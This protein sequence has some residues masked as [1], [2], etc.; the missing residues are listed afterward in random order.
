MRLH[1]THAGA[2]KA[3]QA[4]L[5]AVA[6]F[7]GP[8]GGCDNSCVRIAVNPGGGIISG[9]DST[10]TAPKMTGN[11]RVS[12]NASLAPDA[13]SEALSSRHIFVSLRGVEALA[14]ALAGEDS[15]GWQEMAPGLATRPVQVDLLA[16][17]TDA[18]GTNSLGEATIPQGVYN[19]V[20]LRFVPN[21]PGANELV[22]EENACGRAGFNCVVAGDDSARPIV[23]GETAELRV[24]AER[25][26][27]RFFRVLPGGDIHLAVE[28]D[29]RSS[30]AVP[31]GDGVRL[32]PAFSA[33]QQAPCET[34]QR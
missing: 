32:F 8:L 13:A 27:G 4:G 1:G 2:A 26:E 21:Q 19:Q 14:A 18:C 25:I 6:L 34:V 23:W 10:C 20:R 3:F 12:L 24:P 9:T 16:R 29:P 7:C 28:F 30:M 22:P 31:S 11:V 15:P 17:A 33:T 5:F